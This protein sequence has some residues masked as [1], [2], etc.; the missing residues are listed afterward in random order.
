M[1][2]TEEVLSLWSNWRVSD[3]ADP[4][5]NRLRRHLGRLIGGIVIAL[6]VSALA[7][8]AAT[9][10]AGFIETQYGTDVGDSPTAMDFAP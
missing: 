1:D 8:H 5:P 4:R 3:E 9:L 6:F 7:L 2:L 10:P